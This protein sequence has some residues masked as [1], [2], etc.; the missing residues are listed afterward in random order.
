MDLSL[1]AGVDLSSAE[2]FVR[3]QRLLAG[4]SVIFVL[5]GF[6]LDS[7]IGKALKNVDLFREDGVELFSNLNE[8][9]E[10]MSPLPRWSFPSPAML[11]NL[12]Y[13][14]LFRRDGECIFE[15]MAVVAKK[16]EWVP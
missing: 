10:C 7:E 2:A 6:A 5:C 15:G 13:V 12:W 3:V 16:G 4:R 8:A 11:S 1:V 9:L 14:L